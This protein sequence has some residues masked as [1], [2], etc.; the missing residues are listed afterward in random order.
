MKHVI[1]I[2]FQD[3]TT[4]KM[5]VLFQQTTDTF[6]K[7]QDLKE[8]VMPLF[9]ELHH[10]QLNTMLELTKAHSCVLIYFKVEEAKTLFKGAAFNLNTSDKPFVISTQYKKILL[11]QNPVPFTIADVLSLEV[12]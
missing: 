7:V 4:T 10:Q 3:Q 9:L 8:A 6:L 1:Q 12:L 2:T 5:E 11:L